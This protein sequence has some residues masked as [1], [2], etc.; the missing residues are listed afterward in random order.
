MS[1]ENQIAINTESPIQ[2]CYQ[3]DEMFT[4]DDESEEVKTKHSGYQHIHS[5]C[6]DD[7]MEN[8]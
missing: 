2:F 4:E 1:I 5:N 3:C 6:V 8:T 7:F